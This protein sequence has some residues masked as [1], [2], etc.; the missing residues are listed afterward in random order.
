MNTEPTQRSARGAPLKDCRGIIALLGLAL[1]ALIQLP[2]ADLQAAAKYRIAPG[3]Q[4]EISVVGIAELQRRTTV[5][6]DGTIAFPLL[7]TLKV[8]GLLLPEARASIKSR[9]ALKVYNRAAADG[10]EQPIVIGM[11]DIT[12]VVAGYRPISV[13]GAVVRAGQFAYRPSITI[14]EV[15]ALS[16]GYALVPTAGGSPNFASPDFRGEY[17]ALWLDLAKQQT[18]IWRL[19]A[20]LENQELDRDAIANQIPASAPISKETISKIVTLNVDQFNTKRTDNVRQKAFLKRSIEQMKAQMKT[21]SARKK[22]FE[23]AAA[24]DRAEFDRINALFKKGTVVK[25]RVVDARRNVLDSET[26]KLEASSELMRLAQQNDDLNRQLDRFADEQRI[27]ILKE[28]EAATVRLSEIRARL[29]SVSEKLHMAA[30]AR[31]QVA[32][33]DAPKPII[34][35]H[36]SQAA[37]WTQQVVDESFEL[38]PGDIVEISVG[39]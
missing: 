21:V 30:T 23:Q 15:V 34:T 10:T 19:N 37:S 29:Q 22:Q 24:A 5:E 4:L 32:S 35:V 33:V 12:V 18:A 11:D 3:D 13:K 39:K 28:L 6:S 26:R 14:R 7:G 20:E 27:S 9:L 2:V 36:R 16:G 38:L 8:A 31:T 17:E 25:R 1:L